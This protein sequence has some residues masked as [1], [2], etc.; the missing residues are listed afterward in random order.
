MTDSDPGHHFFY[1]VLERLGTPTMEVAEINSCL[2]EEMLRMIF[3][4]LPPKD[5]KA[6]VLVCKLLSIVG[7]LDRLLAAFRLN[8]VQIFYKTALATE[9]GMLINIKFI[10]R[11]SNATSV[12]LTHLNSINLNI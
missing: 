9:T 12:I 8:G 5:L 7:Q 6:A 4:F 11:A 10:S 1:R 2:P 3:S